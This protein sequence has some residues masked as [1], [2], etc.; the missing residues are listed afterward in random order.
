MHP[1][2][3][4]LKTK[5][6]GGIASHG[7]PYRPGGSRPYRVVDSLVRGVGA[8]KSSGVF[9]GYQRTGVGLEGLGAWGPGGGGGRGGSGARLPGAAARQRSTHGTKNSKGRPLRCT[10]PQQSRCKVCLSTH[11]LLTPLTRSTTLLPDGRA[12]RCASVVQMSSDSAASTLAPEHEP[13]ENHP[14][15][16][17]ARQDEI[18]NQDQEELSGEVIAPGGDG[19]VVIELTHEERMYARFR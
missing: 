3:V 1:S 2:S 4:S 17:P 14:T 6:S 7:F 5:E 18:K 19:K 15:M 13:S 9:P 16:L 12:N 10:R 11:S 8:G